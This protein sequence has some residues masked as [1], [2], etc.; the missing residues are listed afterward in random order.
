MCMVFDDGPEEYKPTH[1]AR[2]VHGQRRQVGRR[3][4]LAPHPAQGVSPMTLAIFVDHRTVAGKAKL[5]R[6]RFRPLH[7]DRFPENPHPLPAIASIGRPEAESD[8]S[9]AQ[10]LL[11]SALAPNPTGATTAS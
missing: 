3:P 11:P 1:I 6:H 8:P 9:T 4:R 7:P 5:H 2:A 10:L